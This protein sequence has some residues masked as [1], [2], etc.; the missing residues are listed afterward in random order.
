MKTQRYLFNGEVTI[1]C[2]VWKYLCKGAKPLL[3]FYNNYC[4]HEKDPAVCTRSFIFCQYTVLFQ[5]C[6]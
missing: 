1:I 6:L 2:T 4:I 3:H 5:I